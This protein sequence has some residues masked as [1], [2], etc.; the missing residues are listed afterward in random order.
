LVKEAKD[1]FAEM[2]LPLREN[3]AK[4]KGMLQD[5]YQS[6]SSGASSENLIAFE[7]PAETF[8][9]LESP[10][11]ENLVLARLATFYQETSRYSDFSRISAKLKLVCDHVGSNLEWCQHQFCQMNMSNMQGGQLAATL[12]GFKSLFS[13]AERMQIP[14]LAASCVMSICTNYWPQQDCDNSLTWGQQ[15]LR[16]SEKQNEIVLAS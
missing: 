2:D 11:E 1:V 8:K 10:A 16:L 14:P 13:K 12:E 4:L 6:E 7:M 15:A 3:M 9:E 5:I